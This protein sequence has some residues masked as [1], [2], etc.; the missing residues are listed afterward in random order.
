MAPVL[1]N[2]CSLALFGRH[3]L[4]ITRRRFVASASSLAGSALALPGCS[5]Q[6]DTETYDM[7]T[8]RTWR[9]GPLTGLGGDALGRDLVRCASMAPSSHNT[10]CWKFAITDKVITIIPDLTRRCP[11]VDPDDHHLFVSLGCAA[12]NLTQGALAHGFRGVARFDSATDLVHVALEQTPAQ[13]SSLF[14]AIPERQC[15]RSDYDAKPL[16]NEELKLL[17]RAGTSDGVQLL[18]ITERIAMDQVLDQVV[19][20]NTAQMADALFVKEL[21]SWI[22][23]NGAAAVRSGDGL[24]SK[25][26]GNPSIPTWIGNLAFNWFFSTKGENEKLVRQIRSSSGLAVFVGDASDKAHWVNVGRCYQRFALQATA[27]GIRN[28]FLNQPVEV[29]SHRSNFAA[30][31]GMPGQRPDLLVRFG[32]GPLMPRSLRRPVSAVLV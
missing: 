32:R 29:I 27:L 30:A 23:Y 10:Q 19:Q 14:K 12:E 18:L 15:S 16:S 5:A 7:V 24:Y 8:S 28:A 3:Q 13:P 26:T 31:I 21:K 1:V 17:Q 20:A 25:C 11:A 2:A 22:R 9:P 6:M 4:M